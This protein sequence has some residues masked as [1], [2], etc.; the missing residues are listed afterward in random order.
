MPARP[1]E[2]DYRDGSAEPP[3]L[4]SHVSLVGPVDRGAERLRQRV[5]GADVFAAGRGTATHVPLDVGGRRRERG[6]LEKQPRVGRRPLELEGLLERFGAEL[7]ERPL[8]GSPAGQ[9]VR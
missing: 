9:F 2:T 6:G 5:D 1:L 3:G 7:D 4:S 8:D